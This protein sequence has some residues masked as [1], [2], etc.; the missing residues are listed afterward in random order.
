MVMF[1][2]PRPEGAPVVLR[3]GRLTQA[4]VFVSAVL[5]LGLGL[6]PRWLLDA[7]RR[8]EMQIPPAAVIELKAVSGTDR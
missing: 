4:V 7:A 2:K 6:Y 1:M 8:G 5:I 3:T